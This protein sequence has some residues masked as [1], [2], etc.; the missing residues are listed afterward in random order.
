VSC[1]EGAYHEAAHAVLAISKGIV[2]GDL[3]IVAD[4]ISTGSTYIAP[5]PEDAG[6]ELNL[7]FVRG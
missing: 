1:R 7:S 6:G 4:D 3:T 2:I 5:I